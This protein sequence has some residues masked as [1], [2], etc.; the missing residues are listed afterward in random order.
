MRIATSFIQK[1]LLWAALPA[2]LSLSLPGVAGAQ[3]SE[4]RY[5]TG[6]VP[7]YGRP[8]APQDQIKGTVTGFD[9][10]YIVYMRD[11]RGYDDHISMHDGTVI[12]PTGTRLV[13][14]M[15]VT[16]YGQANGPTFDAY[17]I[18]VAVAYTPYGGD[19][20][21]GG[22]GGYGGGYYAGGYPYYGAGYYGGGYPYWG[23]GIGIG[24]GFGWGCCGY[25]WSGYYR[26]WGWGYRGP[27]GYYRGPYG[28]R[29]GYYGGYRGGYYGGYRGGYYGGYRG[30]YYGG[31]RGGYNGGYRGGYN[32]GGNHGT[33]HGSSGSVHGSGGGHGGGRPR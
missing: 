20:G 10:A 16:I 21:Y 13:E 19:G 31:Y 28:Y 7:S 12:N 30:G 26:P 9:G 24:L 27:W 6:P 29:G 2:V 14:G 32:G 18:D 4:P 17:R 22:Y 8:V 25:G 33:V 15:P 5:G 23:I 11:D 1:T 3:Q